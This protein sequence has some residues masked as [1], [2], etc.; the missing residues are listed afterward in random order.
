MNR[1]FKVMVVAMMLLSF[2]AAV[3]PVASARSAGITET[4]RVAAIESKVIGDQAPSAREFGDAQVVTKTHDGVGISI[5]NQ[6]SRGVITTNAQGQ[7]LTMTLP[8]ASSGNKIGVA[9]V[10]YNNAADQA[11]FV[12][13][14]TKDGT[15]RGMTVLYDSH[16]PRSYTFTF[17]L[18]H[19]SPTLRLKADGSV[20][21]LNGAKQVGIIAPAWA[22]DAT[23]RAVP[24]RYHVSGNSLTQTVDVAPET[25]FPV[26]ADPTYGW[27]YTNVT[28]YLNRNETY[29]MG[30]GGSASVILLGAICAATGVE[31]SGVGCA[32]G[33]AESAVISATAFTSWGAGNCIK[34]RIYYVGVVYPEN[35]KFGARGCY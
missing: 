4:Q 24:T 25:V 7:T 1:S 14:A 31:T 6:S 3:M 11:T 19:A 5:F 13:E 12:A 27:G 18:G 30:V 17:R 34:I 2:F 15:V 33:I 16:A 9:A 28:V 20:A 35:Q 32:I 23:G 22:I 26:V 10:A 21:V 8:G 29:Q